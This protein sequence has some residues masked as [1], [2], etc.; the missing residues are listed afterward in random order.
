MYWHKIFLL[1]LTMYTPVFTDQIGAVTK[2]ETRKSLSWVMKGETPFR[3]WSSRGTLFWT[4]LLT[5]TS[6]LILTF[7]THV[8]GPRQEGRPTLHLYY[9]GPWVSVL[10]VELSIYRLDGDTET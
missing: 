7:T 4:S 6:Y 10:G 8:E 3:L 1:N 2:K 5:Q 9:R